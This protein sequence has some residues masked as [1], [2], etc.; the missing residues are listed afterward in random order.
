MC[1]ERERASEIERGEPERV[2]HTE[3]ENMRKRRARD[4]EKN[5]LEA[6]ADQGE[7]AGK[8]KEKFL[9]DSRLTKEREV[10]TRNFAAKERELAALTL[11]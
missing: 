6:G 1:R 2:C 5:R 9:A 3:R 8:S 11:S 10:A 7:G 4:R